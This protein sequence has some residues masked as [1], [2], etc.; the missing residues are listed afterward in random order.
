MGD[1][2]AGPDPHDKGVRRI[3]SVDIRLDYDLGG[4][5]PL[6][7]LL[8]GWTHD[9]RVWELQI[10]DLESDFTV[11][12]C[13]RRG[14]G[15]SE[16]APDPSMDADDL[17]VLLGALD[18]DSAYVLGHSQGAQ[19][20][21]AFALAYPD[22]VD[23]LVLAG[24]P[25]L[26]G[27]GVPWVGPDGMHVDPFRLAREEGLDAVQKLFFEHPMADGFEDG[28]R[29][30]E[31]MAELWATN[32]E[33]ALADP[34]SQTGSAPPPSMEDLAGLDVPT[35]VVT[36]EVEI[37][38]FQLVS[39]AVAYVLPRGERRVIEGGGH[40]V[41]VQEPER[42]NAEVRRFLSKFGSER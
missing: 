24:T 5:G 27:F 40:A 9:R 12:R 13:D 38:Y 4:E 18:F 17:D 37:P 16:G 19:S 22:R 14:W 29:S 42:F 6:L 7:V 25:P 35:L 10:A 36:G 32:A 31:I 23:G 33:R 2:E 26:A 3:E 8:H 41:H 1:A 11:L 30:A 15:R 28:G 39:D 34:V 21:L 20:A